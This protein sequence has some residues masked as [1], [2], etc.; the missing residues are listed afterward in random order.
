MAKPEYITKV[1]TKKDE[2]GN[3]VKVETKYRID[4]D[5]V[6][7][8]INEVCLEFMM[9]YCKAK[10]E[11]A[12]LIEKANTTITDKQGKERDYP[13]VNLRADFMNKFFPSALKGNTPA[14]KN[15]M[16]K[17]IADFFA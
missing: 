7:S 10:K 15:P 8:S 6:P 17:R 4:A 1:T 13:F 2:E 9:N 11:G 14:E 16:K 5:F 3:N 12:W